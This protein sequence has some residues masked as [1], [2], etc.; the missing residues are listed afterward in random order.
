MH[1]IRT[2]KIPFIQSNANKMVYASSIGLSILGV[3]IP[4]TGLGKVIGLVNIPAEYFSVII[5]VPILYCFVAMAAKK[6]Y[7]K[8]FGEWI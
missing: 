5:I 6:I 8:K 7:I 2:A 4:F 3:L 1:I